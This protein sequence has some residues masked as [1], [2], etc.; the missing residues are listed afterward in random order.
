MRNVIVEIDF[1]LTIKSIYGEIRG[2]SKR[3]LMIRIQELCKC[4]WRVIFNQISR[5]VSCV[6]DT[7][8]ELMKDSPIGTRIFHVILLLVD[9][10]I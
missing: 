4:D 1:A 10:Q 6:I 3:D 7:L 5:E 9:D 8:V 2:C